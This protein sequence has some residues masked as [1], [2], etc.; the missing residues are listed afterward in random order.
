M[1]QYIKHLE[2]NQF[3]KDLI[4]W[5]GLIK[6]DLPWRMNQDPYRILVSE[7][8]LQ[9]TQVKTV[10]P[11]YERFMSLFPTTKELAVADEQTL[12]K[13]WEG[14]G[15]YSRARNL[16]ESAKM[17]EALGG[18]PKTH[19]EILTLKGVGPYTA[20]AIGSIAFSLPVPAVDGNVFRVISRICCIFE[21]ITKAKT[22]KIFEAVVLELIS[23]KDPSAFNQ[24]LMELGA[25]I[26]K[27]KS[28]KCIECPLQKHC[29]AY[30]QGMDDLL[31]V[32]SKAGKQ[33]IIKFI[34]GIIVNQYGEILIQKRQNQ[35][36]LANFYEF[37]SFEY[38]GEF[39]PKELLM[40]ELSA[41]GYGVENIHPLGEFKH[42]FS[43]L[44]WEME[45][46]QV[47]VRVD[48][49]KYE[50]VEEGQALWIKPEN[51]E[52]YPLVVAHSKMLSKN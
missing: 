46:Y 9:Q 12:L 37:K 8:M 47:E 44:I 38:K 52:D 5:Y 26:C 35:G 39:E 10:I 23:D 51:L 21:D 2:I 40:N 48:L 14:L 36:L 15:Y 16:Q 24:G 43:H 19:E 29:L 4:D 45:S 17:I 22:R 27:P 49:A 33:K 25:T 28:P 34:V 41:L 1:N 13:A 30:A 3:Q 50:S 20:G 31:P 7:I 6:R 11:Y 42:V 32:K 18:F